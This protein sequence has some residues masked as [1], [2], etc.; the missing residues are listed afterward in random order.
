MQMHSATAMHFQILNQKFL[1]TDLL[2]W[3]FSQTV[4]MSG[5]NPVGRLQ[6]LMF[7]G[8]TQPGQTAM[9]MQSFSQFWERLY[10]KKKPEHRQIRM[11]TSAKILISIRTTNIR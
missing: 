3:I 8:R 2:L 7:P 9:Q 5:M 10:M 11:Y 1:M 4:E 6:T